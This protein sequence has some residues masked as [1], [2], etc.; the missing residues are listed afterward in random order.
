MRMFGHWPVL[1]HDRRLCCQAATRAIQ[2]LPGPRL[3]TSHL[4]FSC[5][6]AGEGALF[7]FDA[8][9]Q[10]RERGRGEMRLNVAPRYVQQRSAADGW[11]GLRIACLRQQVH[12]LPGRGPA[13]SVTYATASPS[14]L[15]HHTSTSWP[16]CIPCA[17]VAR[18]GQARLVMRQKGNLRLLL[19]ANLWAEMQVSKMEGGKV[20]WVRPGAGWVGG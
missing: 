8:S 3:C 4:D 2:P 5:H 17:H 19:N 15:L 7:E 16:T 1:A 13:L 18:S 20:G 6:P 9:K 10:W 14:C 12:V 11:V